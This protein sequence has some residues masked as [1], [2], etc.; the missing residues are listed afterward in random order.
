MDAWKK[1]KVAAIRQ[2]HAEVLVMR[3]LQ[4]N[5]LLRKCLLCHRKELEER[6]RSINQLQQEVVTLRKAL[7]LVH[8]AVVRPQQ[9]PPPPQQW[10]AEPV[11]EQPQTPSA[12]PPSFNSPASAVHSE[13]MPATNGRVPAERSQVPGAKPGEHDPADALPQAII[14][15]A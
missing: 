10:S 4:T 12:Q 9:Q 2:P 3:R 5:L 7:I 11:H 14:Y 8:A 13:A 6:D 1:P 15:E